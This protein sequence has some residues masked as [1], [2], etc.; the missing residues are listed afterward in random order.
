METQRYLYLEEERNCTVTQ[1][2]GT[3]HVHGERDEYRREA[4]ATKDIER[5]HKS[6]TAPVSSQNFSKIL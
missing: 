6:P 4:E 3:G 1:A 5:G 2:L